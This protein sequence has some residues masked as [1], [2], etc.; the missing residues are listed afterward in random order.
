MMRFHLNSRLRSPRIILIG[1]TVFSPLSTLA[2]TPPPKNTAEVQVLLDKTE[3]LKH[4]SKIHDA[5]KAAMAQVRDARDR[6]A[7]V[8]ALRNLSNLYQ[9]TGQPQK[10]LECLQQILSIDREIGDRQMEAIALAWIGRFYVDVDRQPQKAVEFYEQSLSIQRVL[11]DKDRLYEI[12]TDTAE[13]YQNVGQPQKALEYFQEALVNRCATGDQSGVARVLFLIGRFYESTHQSQKALEYFRQALPMYRATGMK[14]NEMQVLGSLAGVFNTI[15][16]PAM[17]VEL[18][19]QALRLRQ[20]AGDK[21]GQADILNALCSFYT[22]SGQPEKAIEPF[23]QLLQLKRADGDKNAEE[24]VLLNLA[25]C[26]LFVGQ[27]EKALDLLQ[28]A[29]TAARAAR[30]KRGEATALKRIGQMYIGGSLGLGRQPQKALPYYRHA[31]EISRAIGDENLQHEL[32]ERIDFAVWA[33]GNGGN[34]TSQWMVEYDWESQTARRATLEQ[35]LS[36]TRFVGSKRLEAMALISLGEFYLAGGQQRK[37]L[38][39]Y[40]EALAISR[41]ILDRQWEAMSLRNIGTAYLFVGQPQKALDQLQEALSVGRASG[42]MWGQGDTYRA[43]GKVYEFTREPKKA[44]AQFQLARTFLNAA[45]QQTGEANAINDISNCYRNYGQPELALKELQTA[46]KIYRALGRKN[47]EAL[48]LQSLGEVYRGIGQPGKALA[49]LQNARQIYHFTQNRNGE[50]EVLREIALTYSAA[51]EPRKALAAYR[52]ALSVGYTTGDTIREADILTRAGAVQESLGEPEKALTAYRQ[53]IKHREQVREALGA[54]PETRQAYLVSVLSA[55]YR[56]I[57]LLLRQKQCPEA[58]ALAQKTKARSL[59]DLLASGKV[60]LSVALTSEE[61]K[62]EQELRQQADLLNQKMVNE[63]VINEVGA[64]KRFSA[65]ADEL[66][67]TERKLE[68]LNDTLSARHPGL[69]DRR[70]AR[71]TTLEELS[72]SLPNDTALLEYL[73]ISR[74]QY[75]LFVVTTKSGKAEVKVVM[76]PV[77]GDALAKQCADFHTAC[78]DPRKPW[79]PLSKQM[80]RLLFARAEPLL[81]G[82]KRLILC[83]DGPLWEVAFAAL[84]DGKNRSLL[85]RFTLSMAYSATGAQAALSSPRSHQRKM[86]GGLLCFANPYFGDAKRFGDLDGVDGQRPFDTPSRPFDTPSRPFDTPSRQ[87]AVLTRGKQIASLPGTQKEADILKKAFSDVVIYTGKEAKEETARK[88]M[89]RYR[90]LHFATHGFLNDTSPLLSSLVLAQPE[91]GSKEDG[92]LTARE[93]FGMELHAELAVLS[94]C[95]TGR[96]ERLSGEGVVGLTWALFAAGCPSSVVSGW[97]VDD[98]GTAT[99]MGNFYG[100]LKTGKSKASALR[101]AELKL[102]RDGK[103]AH[104]YYWAAFSLIG[105]GR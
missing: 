67:K 98:V 79:K 60:D 73:Q 101:D 49:S 8:V 99:L 40:V 85:S 52:E 22:S 72:R 42:D 100:I 35:A 89:G 65:F 83:P 96:G 1:L 11:E 32:L 43:I 61:R 51:R 13:L 3:T 57:A 14:D 39:Y 90:Y 50:V 41:A 88:E 93:I 92:F 5:V 45:G 66:K 78:A 55:Y 59:L 71:T 16:Q 76:L 44:L 18:Y 29:L 19:Q 36:I 48:T 21:N 6:S 82:K 27:R 64:K 53:A 94:A 95:N 74:D 75:A 87:M 68:I 31:F 62:Q 84:I 69:A 58:F 46:L 70:V 34:R 20:A 17:G 33:V 7:Q 77:K 81:V 12:L 103:H 4:E 9:D 91:K 47:G 97:S 30:D 56:T 15:G 37:A 10:A 105:D 102:S 23:Q 26:F 2:Q 104:P 24:D 54:N 38:E 28:P 25:A 80:Y 63:G 86:T